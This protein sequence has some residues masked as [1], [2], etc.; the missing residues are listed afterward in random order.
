VHGVAQ[1]QTLGIVT[2]MINSDLKL[3]ARICKSWAIFVC[4]IMHIILPPRWGINTAAD[5]QLVILAILSVAPNRWLVFSASS[6]I[7]FL[8]I[9]LYPLHVFI[10]AI[11]PGSINIFIAG[12]MMA[13]FVFAPLPLSLII[14]Y[15]RLKRGENIIYA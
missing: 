3:S 10:G 15:I 7:I 13:F 5:I 9:S 4:V 12:M 11:L 8:M 14:S 2:F 6:F 1:F